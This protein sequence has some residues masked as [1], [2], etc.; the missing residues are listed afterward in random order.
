MYTGQRP[1]SGLNPMQIIFHLTLRKKKLQFPAHTPSQLQVLYTTLC[2][3]HSILLHDV[4][5]QST[6]CTAAF[7]HSTPQNTS[8]LGQ[9]TLQCKL[10][11]YYDEF[12]QG[13][14]I[15][16]PD[17]V[18]D[19]VLLQRLCHMISVCY[20]VLETSVVVL[21]LPCFSV[22]L[23]RLACGCCD[24]HHELWQSD[25]SVCLSHDGHWREF[26]GV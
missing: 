2:S 12:V 10:P 13:V 26:V 6:H 16:R 25:G 1:W 9:K 11:H 21:N 15:H 24:A 18:T 3:Y 7:H 20:K 8:S 19:T 23:G 4:H 17:G 14:S 5:L 22:L